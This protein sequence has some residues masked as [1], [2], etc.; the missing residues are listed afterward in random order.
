M[1][2]DVGAKTGKLTVMAG[3]DAEA[4]NNLQPLFKAVATNIIH[5]GPAGSGKGLGFRV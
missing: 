3:G 4:F 2:G 1:A 5:A